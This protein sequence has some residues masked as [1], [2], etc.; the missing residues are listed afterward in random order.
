MA[1]MQTLLT[2]V[3]DPISHGF[4]LYE[5]GSPYITHLRLTREAKGPMLASDSPTQVK[6]INLCHIE[7][8]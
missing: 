7:N 6:E 5:Q 2:K 3:D 1:H 8:L 4:K